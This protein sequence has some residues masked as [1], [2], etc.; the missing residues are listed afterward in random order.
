[1][2]ESKSNNRVDR[3][4]FITKSFACGT[5]VGMGCPGL[6]ALNIQE[7]VSNPV[8]A[9]HKFQTAVNFTYEQLFNFAFKS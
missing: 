5:F 8:Q 6:L 1:M 3:R 2:E 9:E 7:G 4:D